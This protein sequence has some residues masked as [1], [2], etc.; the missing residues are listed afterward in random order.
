MTRA[1]L[2]S[3]DR[4]ARGRAAAYWR[5]TYVAVPFDGIT[6]EGYVDLVYRDDDGGLVVVDYKTDAVDDRPGSTRGSR[7]TGS[8]PRRT[9]SRSPRRRASRSCACVFVF[10][11]PDGRDEVEFAGADLAAAV[12]EVR[13]LLAAERDDPSPA[14]RRCS[15]DA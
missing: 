7:T 10:L 12:A 3:A 5:E 8:R 14:R 11:D 4:A 13:A 9:R 15:S 6:L 2:A 1:A